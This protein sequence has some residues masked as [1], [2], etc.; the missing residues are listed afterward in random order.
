MALVIFEH[1]RLDEEMAQQVQRA[2]EEKP[3]GNFVLM[4]ESAFVGGVDDQQTLIAFIAYHF[5]A[6]PVFREAVTMAVELLKDL[7]ERND[8]QCND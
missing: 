2:M 3:N 4:T 7:K 8:K 6:S 5:E 1:K